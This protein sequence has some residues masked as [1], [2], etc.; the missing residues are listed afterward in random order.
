MALKLIDEP[1]D[2]PLTLAEAKDHL[3]VTFDDDDNLIEALI[4]A[5]RQWA[6]SYLGRALITQTWEWTLDCLEE[7]LHVPLPPLQSVVSVKYL[8]IA[9]VE[10]TLSPTLYTVDTRSTPGRIVRAYLQI[11]PVVRD[12]IN[13]VTVK[14]TAGYGDNSGAVPL[15]LKQGLLLLIGDL[16]NKREHSIATISGGR[17]NEVPF[18]VTALLD[19]Y[20]S[21]Y[22][23]ANI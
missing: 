3:R 17:I 6:E 11:Y 13:V 4:G 8:D 9:G 16:Y 21:Y 5:A 22:R 1:G 10:Q 2:E 19:P 14:F 18:G 15:A 20:R 23:I 12:H 7:C